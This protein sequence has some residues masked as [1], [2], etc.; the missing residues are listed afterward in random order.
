MSQFFIVIAALIHVH[1]FI[2]E[3]LLWGRP[4]TNKV[5]GVSA[6]QAAQNKLFA[7]NQG[8]YNL[9]LALAAFTGAVLGPT[10]VVGLTLMIYSSLSM[11]GAAVVL[12][13]SQKKLIKAALAQ[14][15]APALTLLALF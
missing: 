5:F 9:F 1:I 2:L 6:E 15:L 12:F 13:I 11:L 4:R 3:S 7:L 8:Y 14:G 10:E